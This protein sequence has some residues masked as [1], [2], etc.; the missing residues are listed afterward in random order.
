MAPRLAEAVVAHEYGIAA[1]MGTGTATSRITSGQTV[2]V[3][4]LAG[5]SAVSGLRP[6]R[7]IEPASTK[8]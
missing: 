5:R 8:R 3:D 4:V 2:T 7:C 6:S 1:V